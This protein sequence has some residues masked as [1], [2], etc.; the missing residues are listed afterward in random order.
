MTSFEAT[1]SVFNITNE[2]NS[3][4]ITTPGHWNS[5]FAEKTIDELNKLL[6]LRSVNDIELHVEQ[7][8][9][10][11]IFLIKDYSLSSLGSLKLR[12]LKILK[13]S[14]TQ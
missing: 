5:E 7:V 14:K 9:K 6:E 10:K 12:H 13:K 4:S 11:G 3:L 2:N 8:K 1:N